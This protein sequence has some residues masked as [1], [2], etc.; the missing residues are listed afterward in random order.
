MIQ[1]PHV[2]SSRCMRGPAAACVVQPPRAWSSR[3][4]R[5][6]AA[7][8]VV[9]PPPAKTQRRGKAKRRAGLSNEKWVTA[10]EP[11]F[12]RV[13]LGSPPRGPCGTSIQKRALGRAGEGGGDPPPLFRLGTMES[14]DELSFAIDGMGSRS[15][16]VRRASVK[17]CT[18]LVMDPGHRRVLLDYPRET[19]RLLDAVDAL[20]ERCDRERKQLLQEAGE[21]DELLSSG[22]VSLLE[23][24]AVHG[25]SSLPSVRVTSFLVGSLTDC[26][27]GVL[28]RW[29]LRFPT[30]LDVLRALG[31]TDAVAA[32]ACREVQRLEGNTTRKLEWCLELLAV[33]EEAGR[34][35]K[36]EGGALMEA[37]HRV[38]GR[39]ECDRLAV[40]GL[41]WVVHV[42]HRDK[43]A[44]EHV[45]RTLVPVLE[46]TL[47]RAAARRYLG[48]NDSDA[49]A[50]CLALGVTLNC[51]AIVANVAEA[52]VTLRGD[53]DT[54]A[55][56]CGRIGEHFSATFPAALEAHGRHD[57]PQ[58]IA[59]VAALSG[60]ALTSL[61]P[62]CPAAADCIRRARAS[63]PPL[64]DGQ[65]PFL[66]SLTWLLDGHAGVSGFCVH[67][68]RRLAAALREG[69]AADDVT[70][71]PTAQHRHV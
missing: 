20:A 5:G 32:E 24:L 37:V 52:L 57:E 65:D 26:A 59:A 55:G 13:P 41:G 47:A 56:L 4:M 40:V 38:L 42:T 2:W 18:D 30:F 23:A 6:P 19:R 14:L 67:S 58:A 62:A 28:T 49:D 44:A 3:L 50:R 31:G 10:L 17:S 22:L 68:V 21:G 61:I 45:A 35:A 34:G 29:S 36:K 51:C 8:C 7:A 16:S 71:P 43:G 64:D 11:L 66:L 60:M 69:D 1:P 25:P 15:A 9:Q 39:R 33:A 27:L 12:S 63:I 54:C 53:R 48:A 70:D 46:D